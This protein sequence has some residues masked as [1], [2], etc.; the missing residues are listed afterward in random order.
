[1][2]QHGFRGSLLPYSQFAVKR[3]VEGR[4]D[5]S[6]V[7]DHGLDLQIGQKLLH[8]FEAAARLQNS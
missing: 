8:I 5:V 1:M 7:P 3:D 4:A 2:S 6:L